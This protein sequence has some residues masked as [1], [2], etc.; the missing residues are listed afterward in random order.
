MKKTPTLHASAN[1]QNIQKIEYFTD[2]DFNDG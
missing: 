2:A 1:T